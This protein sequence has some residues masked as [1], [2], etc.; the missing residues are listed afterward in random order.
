[1]NHNPFYDVAKADAHTP[2]DVATLFVRDA[3]PIWSDLQCPVNHIVVGARGT[4]KTMALRQLDYRTPASG[5]RVPDFI[6]VYTHVSR[7]SAIFH[8]LF[9][10]REGNADQRLIRQF[11]QVFADYLALEIIRGLCD[12]ADGGRS[13]G[14]PGLQRGIPPSWRV[15]CR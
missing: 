13:A 1:M 12:L 10:D 5:D 11:Q 4:G 3:S 9:A 8:A 7:I 6:G 14:M 2:Q 15:R